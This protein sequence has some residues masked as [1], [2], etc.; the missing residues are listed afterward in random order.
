MAYRAIALD[1]LLWSRTGPEIQRA[2]LEHFTILVQTSR[3]K[4]FNVKQ[5]YHKMGIVRKFLFALQTDLYQP[6]L[7]PALIDALRAVVEASFSPDET[8]KPLLSMIAANIH[9]GLSYTDNHLPYSSNSQADA[10]PTASPHS[11]ISRIDHANQRERAEH[12]LSMLV[13][14]LC[15]SPQLLQKFAAAVP[16]TRICLL[17]L[18]DR[19][20]PSVAVE[21][22]K[23]V[24]T[25]IDISQTFVRKFELVSGW[26]VLKNVLPYAWSQDVHQVAFDIL[27]DHKG[28][29]KTIVR[30]PNIIPAIIASLHRGLQYSATDLSAILDTLS[31]EGWDVPVLIFP[32][33]NELSQ[34]R[35]HRRY[36]GKI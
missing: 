8:I 6:T 26:I 17:L 16:F 13:S 5:R 15:S 31:V 20:S 2:H 18:G 28:D 14:L 11:A 36:W 25:S 21:V 4:R 3:Y 9:N 30:C 12:V 7:L 32:A 24:R 10:G 34:G 27:L 1:F 33:L 29:D 23:L 22:L 19:P 35:H